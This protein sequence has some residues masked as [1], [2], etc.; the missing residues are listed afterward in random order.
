MHLRVGH[1]LA[2][3][4]CSAAIMC[5]G[6][7]KVSGEA[8]SP[9]KQADAAAPDSRLVV[10]GESTTTSEVGDAGEPEGTKLLR[11]VPPV[12]PSASAAPSA[13]HTH[14]VG[15]GP[16]DIRAIVVAHR[17]EARACYERSL[18]DHPGIEGDL[19]IEWTIDPQGTVTRVAL[20]SM[21]SQIAEPALVKCI[22]E[23][24]RNIR[25]VPSR[26][27]FE[28]RAFYPFNFHPRASQQKSPP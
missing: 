22:G 26:G 2:L 24:I 15:R 20:D 17:D 5:G 14:D 8:Q 28:T 18:R 3:L 23:V 12:Q 9:G 25:F 1:G 10:A 19:V 11:T 6:G 13:L 4:L 16:S 21:R 7:Q 27:G